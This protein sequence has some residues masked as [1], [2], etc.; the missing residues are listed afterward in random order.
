MY[1]QINHD[2]K[3]HVC[4]VC[5]KFTFSHYDSYEICKFCEWEDDAYQEEN[6]DDDAGANGMSL[7]E[8]RQDWL[9]SQKKKLK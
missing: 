9:D 6:P 5:G 1:T 4:P 2:S 8:Y 7:N 3:E